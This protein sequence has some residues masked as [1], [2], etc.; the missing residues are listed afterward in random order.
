MAKI[1]SQTQVALHAYN[2]ALKNLVPQLGK[3]IDE[4]DAQNLAFTPLTAHFESYPDPIRAY[5]DLIN[6][7]ETLA[8]GKKIIIRYEGYSIWRDGFS[9][10]QR[11]LTHATLPIR[12]GKPFVLFTCYET[13][14][15]AVYSKNDFT[16]KIP[17]EGVAGPEG[18][19]CPDGNPETRDADYASTRHRDLLKQRSLLISEIHHQ[20]FLHTDNLEW[21]A[22]A[23]PIGVGIQMAL[24]EGLYA[25]YEAARR[26]SL[27]THRVPAPA[28]KSQLPV[29]YFFTP[30][31]TVGANREINDIKVEIERRKK[32]NDSLASTIH[33]LEVKFAQ[34]ESELKGFDPSTV[35]L[36]RPK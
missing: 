34:V 29:G 21:I 20:K 10:P 12:H 6:G 17:P 3:A 24:K 35:S 5:N 19:H 31:D 13:G 14:K 28:L 23:Q 7:I 16:G 1:S 15:D 25:R 2:Q 18:N 9:S 8:K 27:N 36:L 11:L 22:R 32:E 26:S 4:A 30:R 33:D